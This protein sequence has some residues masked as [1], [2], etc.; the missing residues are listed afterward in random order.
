MADDA[1]LREADRMVD[2][3]QAIAAAKVRAKLGPSPAELLAEWLRAHDPADRGD[4][5]R[6]GG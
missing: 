5:D 6:R 2:E 4:P 3:A 1:L